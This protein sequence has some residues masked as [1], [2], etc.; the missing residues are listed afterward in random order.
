MEPNVDYEWK[1]KAEMG[2]GAYLAYP[3]FARGIGTILAHEMGTST[4]RGFA[5][6]ERGRLCHA[7]LVVPAVVAAAA[8]DG[9]SRS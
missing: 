7:D 2:D 6:S 8:G 4:G 3:A 9:I 5:T 1:R